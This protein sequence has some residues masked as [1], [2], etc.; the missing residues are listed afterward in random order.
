MA[1]M[2][3]HNEPE[4]LD[5]EIYLNSPRGAGECA[6]P[7]GIVPWFPPGATPEDRDDAVTEIDKILSEKC[8]SLTIPISRTCTTIIPLH[9]IDHVRVYHTELETDES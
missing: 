6:T 1:G 8:G 5:I 9:S 7:I 4:V 3:E 2:T